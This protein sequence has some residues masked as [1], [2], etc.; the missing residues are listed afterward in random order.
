MEL[1][2]LIAYLA[3]RTVIRGKKALQ[4]LVYFC[5]E[6]GVPVYATYRLHIYGP[7]SNE[8]AEKLGEAVTKE[9]IK[10]DHDGFSFTAG[11]SCRE[12]LTRHQRAIE[13]HQEKIDKVLEKLGKFSP[14]ALELYAT[15]HFVAT[16]LA[17]A[18]GVVSEDEW[19]RRFTGQ[20]G[21]SLPAWKSRPPTAIS[22][23]GAGLAR[24]L[25]TRVND[26]GEFGGE[27]QSS[28]RRE[29]G[30]AWCAIGVDLFPPRL[31]RGLCRPGRY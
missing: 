16:A 13:L 14:L 6:T 9:I 23:N 22:S 15:V 19:W 28:P 12:Y 17:E 21:T 24:R 4:K 2:A 25:R 27:V 10:L 1:E 29:R 3:D 20:R 30:K 18:Y 7:Y 5:R 8:V 26:S 31:R 11:T